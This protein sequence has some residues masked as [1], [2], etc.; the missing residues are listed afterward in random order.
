MRRPTLVLGLCGLLVTGVLAPAAGAVPLTAPI[1]T[2]GTA[3][4]PTLTATTLS[5]T[6]NPVAQ[7]TTYQFDYGLTTSY[8]THTTAQALA[9]G[10]TDV[11][12]TANLS[13][14]TAATTYHF[15]LEATNGSGT[16]D[17]LDGTF[18]TAGTPVVVTG[19][20]TGVTATTATLGG[21]VNPAGIAGA[22]VFQYGPT[23]AYGLQTPGQPVAAG[24]A[25][26]AASRAVTGLTPGTI[27][28]Y[29]LTAT[30]VATTATGADATFVTPS[31]AA[32]S[33]LAVTVS[34]GGGNND[35]G[36][37]LTIGTDPAGNPAGAAST[38]TEAISSQF[39]NQLASFGTCAPTA[40]NNLQGPTAANCGDRSS[41]LGSAGLV[42]RGQSGV[43]ATSDQGFVV[44]TAA[45]QVVLWWHTPA[46]GAVAPASTGRS[47]TTTSRDSR[48]APG[49]RS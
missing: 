18:T 13:G 8:G 40:F 12:V 27:Y 3:T 11:P 14:L 9:V 10:I 22:Y 46:V 2:T 21:T 5:G 28:H 19:A 49:S 37:T 1:V 39:A 24:T 23:T 32:A 6:V 16:T 26:V 44:K 47:S 25:A 35:L 43:D 33:K 31:A 15:R 29:R 4:A 42:I 7:P 34:P 30:N 20:A 41:I 17:G 38:I 45:N 48:R 36:S